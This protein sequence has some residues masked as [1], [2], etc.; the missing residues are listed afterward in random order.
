MKCELN[1]T[2]TASKEL[3]WLNRTHA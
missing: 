1:I 3:S 2:L